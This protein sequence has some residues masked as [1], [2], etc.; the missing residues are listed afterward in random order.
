MGMALSASATE[1]PYQQVMPCLE[2]FLQLVA[3][4]VWIMRIC[5][6]GLMLPV[7]TGAAWHSIIY[8]T[9][10]PDQQVLPCLELFYFIL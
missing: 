3:I 5:G 6:L 8:V 1:F 7:R 2:L 9:E 4:A 10:S